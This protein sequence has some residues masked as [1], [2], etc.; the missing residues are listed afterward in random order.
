MIIARIETF[1]LH[2]PIKAGTKSAAS[3]WGDKNLPAADSLLVKVTTEQGFG[4]LVSVSVRSGRLNWRS[5][6]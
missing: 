6:S 1:P 4:R 5:M 2:I 3:A